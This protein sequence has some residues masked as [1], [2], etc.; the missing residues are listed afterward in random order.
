MKLIVGTLIVTAFVAGSALAQS[1]PPNPCAR[2]ELSVKQSRECRTA[3]TSA[4]SDAERERVKAMYRPKTKY[5][6]NINDPRRP[7][8]Q[9]EER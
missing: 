8:W 7:D 5:P 1:R 3:W 9:G 6:T 2:W 4:T